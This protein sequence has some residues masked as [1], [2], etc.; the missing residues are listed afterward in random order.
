M[1][2][3]LR[4]DVLSYICLDAMGRLHDLGSVIWY[5]ASK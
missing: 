3:A 1:F 5:H 4:N 2:E